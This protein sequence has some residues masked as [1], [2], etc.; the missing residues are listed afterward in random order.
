M[1]NL[2]HLAVSNEGYDQHVALPEAEVAWAEAPHVAGKHFHH[3]ALVFEIFVRSEFPVMRKQIMSR[4][5]YT[6]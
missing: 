3:C 6:Y 2:P 4:L 5:A 1:Q